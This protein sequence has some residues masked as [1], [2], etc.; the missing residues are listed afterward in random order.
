LRALVD[1]KWS[2]TSAQRNVS[3]ERLHAILCAVI[4]DGEQALITD[5]EYLQL[6][7]ISDSACLVSDVWKHLVS[8]QPP[9]LDAATRPALELILNQG[10][11]S[12]RLTNRI[13]RSGN[14]DFLESAKQLYGEL[15]DCLTEGRSFNGAMF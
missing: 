7:G 14:A 5:V 11:L 10:P 2:E 1:E 15:A 12:R 3:V 6:F 4:R 9:E 8:V 13:V